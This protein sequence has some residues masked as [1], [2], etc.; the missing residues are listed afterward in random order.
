MR[1]KANILR[2]S[3]V[4][5]MSGAKWASETRLA[6]VRAQ[7]PLPSWNDGPAKLKEL[8]AAKQALLAKE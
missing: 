7:E 1:T 8:A 3:R 5:P 2:L 4:L 6:I